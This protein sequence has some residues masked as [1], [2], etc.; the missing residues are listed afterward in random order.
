MCV[1]RNKITADIHKQQIEMKKCRHA[2]RN[3]EQ[4]LER[5]MVIQYPYLWIFEI[6]FIRIPYTTAT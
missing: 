2:F 6:A 3:Y 5:N 4:Y 1:D